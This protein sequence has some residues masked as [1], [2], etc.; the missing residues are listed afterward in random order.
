MLSLR[1][2][3]ILTLFGINSYCYSQYNT[4]LGLIFGG[5]GYLGDIGGKNMES[6]NFIGDLLLKQTNVSAGGFIRY[7]FNN[8]W[9]SNSSINYTRL[10]GDDA[11]SL[12]GPRYW[13]NLRFINNIIEITN[14]A[15]FILHKINDLGGRGRY[16]T[17]LDF[18]LHS[19][20]SIFYHSP[21][22][23]KNGYTWV[24]LKPLRTEGYSYP[25]IQFAIPSGGGIVVTHN[26][27]TRF[28]LVVNYRQ[29]FTDYLDDVS[30]I[31]VDPSNLS[32]EAVGYANQF[33]GPEEEA[34]S[35]AAGEKRGNSSNKDVFFTLNLTYSKYFIKNKYLRNQYNR[36]QRGRYK[37]RSF[38]K[39]K[40]GRSMRAK[41]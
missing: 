26:R 21:R 4:D 12:A 16:N 28:G 15:E 10:S 11:N 20:F 41:F 19:G 17:S 13:R 32:S 8:K 6:K 33:I 3:L 24:N 38:K 31:F 14:S 1:H 9:S 35:F 40:Y 29:T 36:K 34:I 18:Y 23:S 7:K 22:G 30:T 37:S 27:F 25:N 2:Y 5:S 39:R